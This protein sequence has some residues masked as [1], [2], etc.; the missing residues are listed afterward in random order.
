MSPVIHRFQAMGSACAIH[1]ETDDPPASRLVALAAEVEVRRIEARYSRYRGDSELSRINLVAAEGGSTD[2]DGETAGL[3]AYAQA[4]FR[5]S[6]GAFDITSG[7]LRRAWDFSA[8]RLPEQREIDALLP[9]IGLDKVSLSGSRLSFAVSGM[10]LDR[11]P[12][13]A[14]RASASSISAATSA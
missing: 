7:S 2:V 12:A 8:P 10:E 1:V 14:A 6:A 11:S 13:I 3:I 5:S 4:C 9:R